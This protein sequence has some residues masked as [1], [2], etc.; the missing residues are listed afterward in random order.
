[1]VSK[2]VF[3]F[4]ILLLGN[5]RLSLTFF[6][7]WTNSSWCVQCISINWIYQSFFLYCFPFIQWVS[8]GVVSCVLFHGPVVSNCFLTT[9]DIPASLVCFLP[10]LESSYSSEESFFLLGGVYWLHFETQNTCLF[11]S[12]SLNMKDNVYSYTFLPKVS[13]RGAPL[14][15][16]GLE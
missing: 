6:F 7:L 4:L 16:K 9:Q 3:F 10:R 1:M 15:S 12:I 8:F 13:H 11:M 5:E 2:E 14:Y